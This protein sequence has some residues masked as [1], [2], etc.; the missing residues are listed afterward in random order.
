MHNIALTAED[1]YRMAKDDTKLIWSPRS[2]ISLY[3]HTA[4]VTT[5]DRFDG[6]I[7][8]GTDWTYSGS[9]NML[10]ELACADQFNRDNLGGYFVPRELWEMA[11]INPALATANDQL[12][13]SLEAT[14]LADVTIFAKNDRKSYRAVIEASNQDVA[15][16]MVSGLPLFGETDTLTELGESC[17][18][19][20]TGLTCGAER[21]VCA[22]REFGSSFQIS[23]PR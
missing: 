16:V 9:A 1:Y 18:P 6:V 3:G 5:F 19:I 17:D 11:T 12:L 21:S 13:G 7:A 22:S 23:S 14:K 8:L 4:Q 15:L 2:N 10:R 20:D